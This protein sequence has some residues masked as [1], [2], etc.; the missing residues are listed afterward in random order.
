[1]TE[2]IEQ[3]DAFGDL[4]G[5]APN[6]EAEAVAAL[7]LAVSDQST[8]TS[9]RIQAAKA[10]LDWLS[11]EDRGTGTGGRGKAK[12]AQNEDPGTLTLAEIEAELA[13]LG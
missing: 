12:S 3:N 6:I 13:R 10:L 4:F 2:K 8:P 7:R 1:M 9:S 5:E 11:R